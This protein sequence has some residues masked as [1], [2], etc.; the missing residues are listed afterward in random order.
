MVWKVKYHKRA[1]CFLQSLDEGTRR[2]GLNRIDE[3]KDALN[4][5]KFPYKRLQI[6]KLKGSWEGFFRMRVG[7]I[8]VIFKLDINEEVIYIYNVHFREG[9]YD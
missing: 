1:I 9:A 3:L 7:K 4:E 8:R 2:R 6:R 5:G